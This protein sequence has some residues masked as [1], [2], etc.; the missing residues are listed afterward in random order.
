MVGNMSNIEPAWGTVQEAA[1]LS[2]VSGMT[3]RRYIKAGR[4]PG[5]THGVKMVRVDLNAVRDMFVQ[6]TPVEA[7]QPVPVES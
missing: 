6:G 7:A 4:L 3:I 1:E 2:G 5:R